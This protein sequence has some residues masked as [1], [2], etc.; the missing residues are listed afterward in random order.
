GERAVR[1]PA[2]VERIA[3]AGHLV[4]HHSYTHG[5]PEVT[6]AE[7]LAHEASLTVEVLERILGARPSCFR[8]PQGKLTAAK[9]VGLWNSAQTIVL[10]NRDP[11]DFARR[12]AEEVRRWVG[13]VTRP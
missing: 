10:W 13:G 12:S 2:I 8:P 9:A 6:T 11:K 1:Y 4:G 3:A 5:R 7:T